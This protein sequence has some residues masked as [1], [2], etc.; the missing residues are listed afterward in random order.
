MHTK[1][2]VV[3]DNI[4]ATYLS[5]NP[6]FHAR[7]KHIEIDFHFI[8]DKVASKHWM[9]T[10]SPAKTKWLAFLLNPLRHYLTILLPHAH[11][12][13]RRVPFVTLVGP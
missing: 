8:R 6:A 12:D 10:S 7:T 13:Q 3:Y 4:E 9:S 1:L 11:E 2:N 5:T